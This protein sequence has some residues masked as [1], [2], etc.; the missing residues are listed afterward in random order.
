[1]AESAIVGW[2]TTYLCQG[3]RGYG[4]LA[5][6]AED[7]RGGPTEFLLQQFHGQGGRKRRDGV[8]QLG[9]GVGGILTKTKEKHRGKITPTNKQ[10]QIVSTAV[11]CVS[12]VIPPII[13][14]ETYAV[15]HEY[16]AYI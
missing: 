1:M 13:S 8:L 16:I 15:L 6:L 7:F 5:E 11:R 3:R 14:L 2:Q 4:L 12:V 9:F 10:Q